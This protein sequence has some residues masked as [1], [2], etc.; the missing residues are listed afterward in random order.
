ML[1]LLLLTVLVEVLLQNL[2]CNLLSLLHFQR[3]PEYKL[4]LGA[5]EVQIEI[6]WRLNAFAEFESPNNPLQIDVHV[7]EFA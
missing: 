2:L 1:K 7:G 6:E 3:K 4:P 5:F